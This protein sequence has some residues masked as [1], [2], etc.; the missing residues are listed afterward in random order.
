MCRQPNHAIMNVDVLSFV[1]LAYRV[2]DDLGMQD[3]VILEETGKNLVLR[4]VAELK[5][6]ELSVLGGNLNK[7]G[8][9]GEIKSLISEMAQYNITPEDLGAFL[10][11]QDVG[12]TLRC[13]MQ[14]ILTMYEGFREYIDGKYI[15]AEE[16]L[17]LLCEVAE[18]SELI[19]DSVIVFD[20]F[21]GFTPIQN[22]LLRVML[23]LADRVIVSLSMDIREDFYHSRGVHELFSM[24]KETVQTLLKIAADAGC[25]VLSPV[26]MEPGEHRRYENAPE[27]FFMEQNLFRP[28]YRKWPK[29]V[30]DISIT[31]LKD[32]RQELSFV[33]R[34]IV[35]LVRTKGYRY[36][37]FA[38]VTGDV[39]QYANYVPETFAQYGIPFFIDQTRNILFHPFIE[40]IRAALEVVE[41]D[42]SYQ[43][44]FRFL[45]SGLAGRFLT[46][47]KTEQTA[48]EDGAKAK[49]GAGVNDEDGA[50]AGVVDEDS[51]EVKAGSDEDGAKA[52]ADAED[53][54]DRLENY[55]LAKGIRGRKRWSEKWTSVTK[56]DACHPEAAQE[57]MALLNRARERIVL[58]FE[59]LCELFSGKKHT[60]AEQTY[61]LYEFITALDIEAQLREKQFLLE[62][63]EETEYNGVHRTKQELQAARADL[64]DRDGSHP[65]GITSLLGE[66]RCR[67]K[68]YTDIL[69][70]SFLRQK[71]GE[72]RR[73][74]RVTVRDN[75]HR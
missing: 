74:D 64:S 42:F 12:D 75:R 63:A 10:G 53:V 22:R 51:V 14:D 57:E 72:I 41:F 40:F 62:Q 24:S 27:L 5:K 25:E 47:N 44:V 7:M 52:W 49:A 59:P 70:T 18:E 3:L 50:G 37:D 48:D 32:P 21:T 54:I 9:I 43:S 35:R 11:G 56:R 38:V 58:A 13:K 65:T 17:T 71:V 55:V 68:D 26:I 67:S 46:E 36:R 73:N 28:M 60:V 61:G 31:S 29:P 45:R 66:S 39:P 6:K 20:E 4:K 69:D 8:Y 15:T 16:I 34:E 19:R 23:P 33:A 2:F 1:R 30:N